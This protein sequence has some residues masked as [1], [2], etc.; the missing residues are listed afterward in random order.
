MK[1]MKKL[2]VLLF[3]WSISFSIFAQE[4]RLTILHTN[5]T[6]SQVES[7]QDK[8][9]GN[10]GGALR[11]NELIQRERNLDSNLL[12]LDA[13][14]YFQGTPY[15]NLFGGEVEIA[16]MNMMGYD[17]VTLGNHEFDNGIKALWEKLKKANFQIVCANYRFRYKPMYSLIKPYVILERGGAKIGIFGLSPDLRG[18]SSPEITNQII[19]LDPVETALKMVQILTEENC[20]LIICLSHLGYTSDKPT[21]E[22]SDTQLAEQVSGIDLIIGGHTHTYLP[23]MQTINN[24]KIV[25]AKNKGT[26]VGKIIISN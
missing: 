22:I 11:R 8:Q 13:G 19:F 7:F 15:F 25:Q 3:I 23:E 20:D 5:D 6:H 10:V 1:L 16:L 2:L 4:Y 21:Q 14:D 9:W 18:L 24:V 17:V 26:F 12:L